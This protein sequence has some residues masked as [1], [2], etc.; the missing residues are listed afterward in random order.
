MSEAEWVSLCFVADITMGQ[1]PDSIF[2]N[3]QEI[4]LPFLQ[5]CAEFGARHPLPKVY[6]NPPL[7]IAKNNSILISVRAPVGTANFSD[8]DYCIGRGLAAIKAKSGLAETMYLKYV[9]ENNISFLHRRSQGSTFLAISSADLNAFKIPNLQI[10]KQNKIAA[11]LNSID[12]AIEKTES[13]IAKYQKIKAGLMH[14]LFTRGV[15]ADGKLRPPREQAPEL[16][17]ETPVGWI[18]V[19]WEFDSISSIME[20]LID[21]PFG[22]NLKTEHY[23]IDPGVRVVRLQNIQA[24]SYN[25]NDRAYVSDKHAAFLLRNKVLSGDILIAGLGEDRYPVGRACLYPDNLPPAINKADCFRL[26]CKVDEAENPFVMLYLNTEPARV[27]IRKYEQGVTRPR[28]NS[29]N[30]KKLIIPKPSIKEQKLI[31]GQIMKVAEIIEAE[32]K[33]NHKFIME[34]LGLMQDLLTGKVPVKIDKPDQELV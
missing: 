4:G 34:K 8:Q 2:V 11:I 24:T 32:R 12:T 20:S 13:L 30:F 17:Q 5:G 29:G 26:R 28:I 3:N 31:A 27:Q 6:C 18:P 1:S 19:E 7:R 15:T 33:R 10:N 23:V 9:I 21:G 22:S 16:Y 14:D 25:D